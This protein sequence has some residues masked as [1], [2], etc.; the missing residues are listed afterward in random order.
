MHASPPGIYC[1][2][3]APFYRPVLRAKTTGLSREDILALVL[4][5][6]VASSFL[7]RDYLAFLPGYYFKKIN[8]YVLTLVF[9]SQV[10]T[11]VEYTVRLSYLILGTFFAGS[12]VLALYCSSFD[13]TG[14]FAY[15]M[16]SWVLFFGVIFLHYLVLKNFYRQLGARFIPCFYAG[17]IVMG[18]VLIAVNLVQLG[19]LH[20]PGI[21]DKPVQFISDHLVL[22]WFESDRFYRVANSYVK[23]CHRLNGLYEEASENVAILFLCIL[24][25]VMGRMQ[26]AREFAVPVRKYALDLLVMILVFWIFI[27]AQASSALVFLGVA[28][29]VICWVVFKNTSITSWPFFI[30]ALVTGLLAACWYNGEM[31]YAYLVKMGDFTSVSTKSRVGMTIGLFSLFTDHLF[32]GVGKGMIS[33]SLFEHIPLWARTFEIDMWQAKEGFPVLSSFFGFLAEYGL[34]GFSFV[35]FL[36]YRTYVGLREC[37]PGN[38]LYR[39]VFCSYRI[40]LVFLGVAVQMQVMWYKSC[41]LI[42]LFFFVI[43]GLSAHRGFWI[44]KDSLRPYQSA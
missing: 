40:F 31:L 21:F 32:L 27:S 2:S 1:T 13:D 11:R 18:C 44:E 39:Q 16:T 43:M 29:L 33:A 10:I 28:L 38:L 15:Q 9:I 6:V 4:I 41:V 34:V 23:S 37:A 12:Q 35:L 42:C 5:L 14:V 3:N 7:L 26:A 20:A 36:L 22:Q 25:F 8:V 24:P 19:Y 30:L 17:I